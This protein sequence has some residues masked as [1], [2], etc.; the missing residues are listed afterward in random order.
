VFASGAPDA[1]PQRAGSAV[2][3][4]RGATCGVALIGFLCPP[5][6][7][8]A[9][10]QLPAQDTACQFEFGFKEFADAEPKLIGECSSPVVYDK[11]GNGAQYTR[12]GLLFWQKQSNTVY[13]F[14]GDSLW[15]HVQGHT[16]LLYGSG[17]T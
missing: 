7:A 15:A 11:F 16:Q 13:F 12:N 1:F 2:G 10:Q 4:V 9:F 5:G 3:S 17:R 6:T 14:Q 8:N